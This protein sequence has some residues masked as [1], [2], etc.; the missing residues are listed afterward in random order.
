MAQQEDVAKFLIEYKALVSTGRDFQFYERPER[1]SALL[2][3]GMTFSNLKAELRGLS[4]LDYSSGPEQ[5]RDQLGMIWVFGKEI[6]S[7]EFYI[8]LKICDT[9][10]GRLAICISFHE[11][12]EPIRYPF[13]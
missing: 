11:A 2:S 7:R 5:D 6:N 4:V 8:K 10:P 3:L 12:E 9:N 13:K 1:N